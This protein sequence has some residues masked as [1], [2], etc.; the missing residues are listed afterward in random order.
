MLD[1]LSAVMT[2]ASPP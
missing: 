2:T 1:I